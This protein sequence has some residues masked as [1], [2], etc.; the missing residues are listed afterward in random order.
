MRSIVAAFIVAFGMLPCAG[1]ASRPPKA[2]FEL[3]S[4]ASDASRAERW[5]DAYEAAQKLHA[6]IPDVEWP[7][8]D[9]ACAAARLGRKDDAFGWLEQALSRGYADDDHVR[10]DEDLAG[11]HDDPRWQP[12][13]DA[14]KDAS[15]RRFARQTSRRPDP[16]VLSAPIFKS[17]RK[18]ASSFDAKDKILDDAGWRMSSAAFMEARY[19]L[20]DDR[21][22][23]VR[24]YLDEHP[25]A[26]DREPAAWDAVSAHANLGYAYAIRWRWGARGQQLI[27]EIDAFLKDHPGSPHRADAL[28][29]RAF[30][31]VNVRPEGG[32]EERP[33]TDDDLAALTASLGEIARTFAGTTGGGTALAWQLVYTDLAS[34]GEVTPEMRAMRADLDTTYAN[35]P[36]VREV[37]TRAGRAVLVRMDG[38]DG[39]EGTDLA[40]RLWNAASFTGKVT[41]ID[42][43][44]TWC[45]PCVAEIPT[46]RKAWAEFE[47]RGLQIVGVS[48]DTDDRKTFEAWLKSN[49][50][51]WPQVWDGKGWSTPLARKFHVRGI[52]FPVLIGPDGRVANVD[53]R[54]DALIARIRELLAADTATKGTQ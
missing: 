46:L 33:W 2:Y 11:L 27:E 36:K 20:V 25:A 24:R 8:Y 42:F 47:P 50:V 43:W 19:K 16:E 31:V 18:L 1:A 51:S 32:T 52:P 10:K 39:F 7:C 17:Y 28:I 40:G 54:G 44:A 53:L 6:M 23:A 49:G 29:Y 34:P 30:A 22:A 21:V 38:L 48:L 12:L 14:M 37:L 41:L 5:V 26:K 15:D 3:A 13:L 45:G 9:A 4:A 35:D